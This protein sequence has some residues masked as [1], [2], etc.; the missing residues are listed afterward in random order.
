LDRRSTL[1][2]P[3]TKT[4]LPNK[5]FQ[6]VRKILLPET[7]SLLASEPASVIHIN[8]S[9]GFSILSFYDGDYF[10]FFNSG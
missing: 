7:L 2:Y 9:I 8:E 4:L 3:K 6:W 10:I 5:Q 1:A